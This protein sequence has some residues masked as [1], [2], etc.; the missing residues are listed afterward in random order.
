MT[1][2]D[3]ASLQR[4]LLL[5]LG[6]L[7]LGACIPPDEDNDRIVSYD[8]ETVM[9]EVQA[10]G[11]LEV[12]VP[13]DLYPVAHFNADG[14]LEGF[15]VDLGREVAESLGVR[16]RFITAPS[17]HLLSNVRDEVL[18][19]AFPSLAVTEQRVR[20]NAFTDPYFVGHQRL[21]VPP[22]SGIDDVDDLAGE[23]CAMVDPATSVSLEALN[24]NVTVVTRKLC[25]GPEP[26]TG[27]DL[28]LIQSL[29]WH[30]QREDRRGHR[31]T[32]DQLTTEGFAAVVVPGASAWVDYV[33]AVFDEHKAEG[34]W[35]ASYERW[36]EPYLGAAGEPPD[37]TV[38]EAAALF[39][40]DLD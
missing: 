18:D 34:R 21:L 35:A 8:E 33:D 31:I 4:A 36:I 32:G 40:S 9:G 37:M 10:A 38:E 11:V 14:E 5:L 29:E 20:N 2:T 25:I 12:G 3:A 19:V 6:L 16:A 17:A 23:V 22:G 28:R 7:A 1:R 26:A 13:S 39:P 27:L 30:R 15:G 24:P